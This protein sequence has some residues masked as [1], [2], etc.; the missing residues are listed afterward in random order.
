MNSNTQE[1]K[2]NIIDFYK[3]WETDAIKADL[4]LKRNNFSVLV[5]NNIKDFNLGT[6]IRSA[7]AFLAKEVI[8]LGSKKYNRV[9][10]VGTHHYENLKHLRTVEE[11]VIPDDSILIGIDNIE[12]SIP[13][14]NYSWPKDNH[15]IMAFGEENSG[16]SKEI[17]DKCKDIVYIK[18]YGSVRSLNLG[19]AASIAMYDYCQKTL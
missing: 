9:G 5:L 7:N 2:R 1:D 11:L 15:V 18:Q 19:S 8:I 6:V 16:L 3:Y 17:I 13:I 12:N 10:T 14:E 4:D